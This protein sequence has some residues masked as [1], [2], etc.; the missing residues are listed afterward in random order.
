MATIIAI[1]VTGSREVGMVYG[2]LV[3]FGLGLIVFYLLRGQFSF[4]WTI[5]QLIFNTLITA[6]LFY[7]ALIIYQ[8]MDRTDVLS[9][10]VLVFISVPFLISINKQLLDILTVKLIGGNRV[11]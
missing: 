7:G 2:V 6:L 4:A 9:D 5:L 10:Y 1:I 3:G 11:K 8:N